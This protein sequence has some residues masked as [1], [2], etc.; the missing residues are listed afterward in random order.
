MTDKA[1]SDLDGLRIR[2]A[3]LADRKAQGTSGG[4][5]T[6]GAWTTR[7]LNTVVSDPDKLV[8]AL[9][10]NVFTLRGG[11]SYL[12][13]VAAPFHAT[14]ET[15]VRIWSTTYNSL[16]TYGR[17]CHFDNQVTADALATAVVTTTRDTSFRVDYWADTGGVQSLG[18]PANIS[19]VQETY[20]EVSIQ[21]L[22]G[23]LPG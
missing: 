5:A 23:L 12:L 13:Q 22:T 1:R 2:M 15:M 17:T 18:K 3:I 11:H 19:G 21:R 6:T 14:Q 20:A 4:T 10:S 16:V 8:T 9:A 7:T